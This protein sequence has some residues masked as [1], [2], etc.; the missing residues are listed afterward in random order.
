[1]FQPQI[2][3]VQNTE[4]WDISL[5]GHIS[6]FLSNNQVENKFFRI[7]SISVINIPT[8]SALRSHS[9]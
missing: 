8:C 7:S 5:D 1:M 6:D 3:P 2:D 9:H 4:S